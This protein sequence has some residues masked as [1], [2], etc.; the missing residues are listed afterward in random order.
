MTAVSTKT[1]PRRRDGF[2]P[3]D[4]K[5]YVAVNTVLSCLAKP[6]L[7]PAAAKLSAALVLD[8]P[9]TYSTSEKASA[10]VRLAWDKSADRGQTVHSWIEAYSKGAPLDPETVPEA[11]Q[12]YARAFLKWA[13]QFGLRDPETEILQ[14]EANIYSDRYGYAGTTD[15]IARVRKLT[16]MVDFKSSKDGT[17]Y[18]EVSLQL[19]AYEAGDFILTRDFPPKRI[20][21]PEI[22][23]TLAV[24]LAADGTFQTRMTDAPLEVFLA[25]MRVW[26]WQ[27]GA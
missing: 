7:I 15:L 25:L 5:K 9:E 1:F 20:P 13:D 17:L 8:D 21:M 3:L 10:G 2:Y 16:A 18:P 19:A 22:G 12:G 6:A 23:T 26:Q 11:Y 27:K 24:G 4:G 14:T